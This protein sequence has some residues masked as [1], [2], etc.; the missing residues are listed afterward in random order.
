M[1][2]DFPNVPGPGGRRARGPSYV[3]RI[4]IDRDDAHR[5]ARLRTMEDERR[6]PHHGLA[7]RP[8]R[9]DGDPGWSD[10]VA[11]R[12][13]TRSRQPKP[14]PAASRIQGAANRGHSSCGFRRSSRPRGDGSSAGTSLASRTGSRRPRR[15]DRRAAGR[16]R[17]DGIRDTPGHEGV[18]RGAAV[19]YGRARLQR[20][21]RRA[22][23]R[24][25]T[26]RSSCR[27][28][29]NTTP[30]TRRGPS[31]GTWTTWD[32]STVVVGTHGRAGPRQRQRLGESA[33]RMRRGRSRSSCSARTSARG[34][35]G[36]ARCPTT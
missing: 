26:R 7:G 30:P 23:P 35:A 22:P 19:Q 29:R 27:R 31:A 24:G 34:A 17:T 15:P 8:V 18:F 5:A 14:T 20:R 9:D 36:R 11:R 1:L 6:L 28:T 12:P 4:A 3:A 10:S 2:I 16:H 25:G 21:R 33:M 32:W 13:A